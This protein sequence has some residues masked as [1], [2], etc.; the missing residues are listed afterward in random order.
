MALRTGF[1][2]GGFRKALPCPFGDYDPLCVCP[3]FGRVSLKAVE[4]HLHNEER[5]QLL[6]NARHMMRASEH[7]SA[8]S[9]HHVI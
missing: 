7:V 3:S 6:N 9:I 5:K 8:G 1:S 4:P 2:E